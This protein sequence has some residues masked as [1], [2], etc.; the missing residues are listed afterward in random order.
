MKGTLL[1]KK[2]HD[3]FIWGEKSTLTMLDTISIHSIVFVIFKK[4]KKHL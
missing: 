3:F 1:N 2:F 4:T